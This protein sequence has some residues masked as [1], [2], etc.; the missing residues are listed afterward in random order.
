MRLG[1]HIEEKTDNWS[2]KSKKKLVQAVTHKMKRI[3]VG[4]LDALDKEVTAGNISKELSQKLRSKVLNI[5]NDQIR[6]MGLELDKYNI[7][8]ICYHVKFQNPPED[9]AKELVN[10]GEVISGS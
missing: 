7:E 2:V 9:S 10:K 4:I 1:K 5:A 3:Y 6:N 8:F